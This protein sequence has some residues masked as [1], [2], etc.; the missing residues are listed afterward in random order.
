MATTLESNLAEHPR[1]EGIQQGL[2]LASSVLGALLYAD[3][4]D[5]PLSLAEIHRYQIA[6]SYPAYEIAEALRSEPG[7]IRL[8]S[9]EGD[10][11]CL[12]GRDALFAIRKE[13]AESSAKVWKRARLY[14]RWLKRLPFVRMVAVTGALAVDNLSGRH[15]IDLLVV[16]RPGRVWLCRRGL[17]AWVRFGRL[18]GDD[19]CPNYI[20][21]EGSLEL[22]QRDFFTAHELAQMVPLF[23]GRVYE[24]MLAAN[25]WAL[26]YLPSLSAPAPL[27]AEANWNAQR[28]GPVERVLRR[29]TFDKWERWELERL[30]KKLRSDLGR[31]AEVV[32]TPDQCKGHTG[33]HR[34][35]VMTRYLSCLHEMGLQD[36][37][38][39][40]DAA[41]SRSP[42]S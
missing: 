6:T 5:A 3:L 41:G 25:R 21:S 16:S 42:S 26:A 12:K 24:Q 38:A 36:V 19:L 20:L 14:T 1:T 10:N 13:R 40:L 22:S 30:R 35:A 28:L 17:I 33:L 2:T 15:D 29:S 39:V 32:L 4:F 27:P 11:Y 9:S 23:G 8:V 37:A 18:R 34:A 31:D 7:L